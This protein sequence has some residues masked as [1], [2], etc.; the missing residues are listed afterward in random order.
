[1]KLNLHKKL[2]FFILTATFL[3]YVAAFSSIIYN[4]NK[5]S[6]NYAV[7]QTDY[8]TKQSAQYFTEIINKDV[9]IIRSLKNTFYNFNK[10]PEKRRKELRDDIVPRFNNE[11]PQFLSI[12]V[13]WELYAIDSSYVK[14]FGRYRYLYFAEAG[15]IKQKTELFN[16]EGDELGGLYYFIKTSKREII[17]EPYYDNYSGSEVLMSSL[18]IPLIQ[19]D[20]F[21]GVIVADIALR[22]LTQLVETIKPIENSN[23]FIVSNKGVIVAISDT[24]YLTK[25]IAT[26]YKE[27]EQEYNII[28]NISLGKPVSY[29]TTDSLGQDFYVTYQPVD[30]GGFEIPWSLG[31]AIPLTTIKQQ[32]NNLLWISVTIGVIGL[33]VVSFVIFLI[34]KTITKPL[35]SATKVIKELSTGKI[36]QSQKMQITSTDEIGEITKSLNTLIEGLLRTAKFAEE[37]GI[38]NLDAKFNIISKQD[39]LGNSLLE[40]RKSLKIARL[41]EKKRNQEEEIQRWIVKGETKFAEILREHNKNLKDLSYQVI[42]NLVKYTGA[43]QGGLFIINDNDKTNV[44]IELIASY[45]YNRRKMLRKKIDM[46]VGLIGRAVQ[47]AETIYMTNVPNDYINISSGLGGKNPNS[48]LIVPL[49]FNKVIYAIVELAS[50]TDFKAYIR[51]FVERVGVSIASTIGTV[52]NAEQTDSLVAEL[53]GQSH[54]LTSQEEEMR[55]NMEEMQTTQEEISRKAF[56]LESLVNAIDQVSL[57]A[58]YDFSGKLIRINDKFLDILGKTRSEMLGKFQG[59]FIAESEKK[60]QME[61]IWTEVQRGETK[62]ITQ[63][64][65]IGGRDYWFSEVYAP[66]YDEFGKPEKILNIAVDIT[67]SIGK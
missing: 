42:S 49:Q 26:L 4:I 22:R 11:N 64:V 55:Q 31:L 41:E 50:F 65:T 29:F 47:E 8:I 21:M 5:N 18:A 13:M 12:A 27:E 60:N 63:H 32:A 20:R 48:I 37:I 62:S 67:S 40:M 35:T 17:T 53:Q 9:E 61:N 52:K 23:A 44:Y 2:T 38:G 56:E 46:G 36:A 34:S 28:E 66:I 19:K 43:N 39:K 14:P 59:S 1:M 6:I 3:V 54:E 25:S 24:K 30:I 15:T 51:R 45:A 33:L 10:M 7:S 16:T 57:V 58:E